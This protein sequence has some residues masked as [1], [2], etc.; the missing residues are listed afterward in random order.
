[1]AIVEPTVRYHKADVIY[2]GKVLMASKRCGTWRPEANLRFDGD[3]MATCYFGMGAQESTGLT[4]NF[5]FFTRRLSIL[6]AVVQVVEDIGGVARYR[7]D[8]KHE[9]IERAQAEALAIEDS[10]ADVQSTASSN[11]ENSSKRRKIGAKILTR[12]TNVCS[13]RFQMPIQSCS[14]RPCRKKKLV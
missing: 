5:V 14:G 11:D 4:D 6:R 3:I 2:H 12:G 9:A 8:V 1:M 7:G 10:Y 13:W